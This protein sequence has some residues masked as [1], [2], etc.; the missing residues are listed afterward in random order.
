MMHPDD[1]ELLDALAHESDRAVATIAAQA[2]V[3]LKKRLPQP[4]PAVAPAP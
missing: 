2:A 4:A 3:N 1:Q